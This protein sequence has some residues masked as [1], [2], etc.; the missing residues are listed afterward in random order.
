MGQVGTSFNKYI[1]QHQVHRNPCVEDDAEDALLDALCL[2]KCEELIC[3]ESGL[4]SVQ[5][6][7]SMIVSSPLYFGSWTCICFV[8][9]ERPIG[10]ARL[11]RKDSNLSIFAGLQNP[12]LRLHALTSI[13]PEVWKWCHRYGVLLVFIELQNFVHFNSLV[14]SWVLEKDVHEQMQLTNTC[15]QG[16]E[17]E[18]N[19]PAEDI[20]ESYEV[21]F[22][23]MV[24]VRKA[25]KAVQSGSKI[26]HIW[27]RSYNSIQRSPQFRFLLTF[28]WSLP[29]CFFLVFISR[30]Q[31]PPLNF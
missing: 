11:Q 27:C 25:G 10:P 23:P 5:K 31:V 2:A 30:V 7:S 9:S 18:A 15:C 6:V 22:A 20:H 4:K 8:T 16:W 28:L 14:T 3:V 24:F 19:H 26:Y 13:L 21:V 12:R 29:L 17:D 1:L